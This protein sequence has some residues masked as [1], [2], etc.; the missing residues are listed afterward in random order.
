MSDELHVARRLSAAVLAV[1][2]RLT[3]PEVLQ[4]IVDT[5]REL[6]GARYAALGVPDEAGSFAQFVVSGVSAEV[7]AAIGPLPR[8]HGFLAVMLRDPATQRVAD[9]RAD[10]R[11]HWWPAAHPVLEAFLGVPIISGDEILGALY[12]ANKSG[13]FT[14]AD[15]ELVGVLAAHAAIALTHARLYAR[16]RELTIAEER[17]R[18]AHDL[19]DAVAQRLFGLRLT[20]QAADVLLDRDPA[21][22]RRHLT[23]VTTLAKEATEELQAAVQELRPADLA[24]DGLPA[25]LR[26]QVS[27]LDRAYNGAPHLTYGDDDPPELPM[28][29]R[30]VLFRVAQEALHNAVRHAK[31]TTVRVRLQTHDPDVVRLEI[32]DDGQ[33]FDVAATLKAGRSLGLRSM[34]E[35]AC[36]I[37]ATLTVDSTPGQGTT[38]RLEAR[39]A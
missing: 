14:D 15:E 30:T 10:P 8:Q 27:I 13:G 33:G 21:A 24:T 26:K 19:H 3:V 34:R 2:D 36:A 38:V 28:P 29:A 9:I 35:R 25:A 20:A 5:A 11:F 7:Q 1:S 12:L 39:H 22:A 17:A 4:T 6:A 23:E 37:R 16:N 31:A 18:I 32:A